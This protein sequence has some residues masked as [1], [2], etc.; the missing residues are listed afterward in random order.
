MVESPVLAKGSR[1]AVLTNGAILL[2]QPDVSNIKLELPCP[3]Y[4]LDTIDL[5][6]GHG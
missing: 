1:F 6:N 5:M 2:G 3:Y 4:K